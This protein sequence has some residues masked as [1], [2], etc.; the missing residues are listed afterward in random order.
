MWRIVLGDT[1]T[2]EVVEGANFSVVGFSPS[3]VAGK[4]F[5]PESADGAESSVY[6]IDPL[7][8]RAT[9]A[10]TMD[11]YFAGLFPVNSR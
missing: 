11:G 6:E 8:N 5:N 3:A 1:P 10:F 9:L 4:L 2:A 7:T